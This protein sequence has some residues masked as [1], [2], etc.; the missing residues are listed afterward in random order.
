[1]IDG[2][3]GPQ[4]SSAS[5]RRPQSESHGWSFWPSCSHPE[6]TGCGQPCP[7]TWCVRVQPTRDFYPGRRTLPPRGE[8]KGQTSLWARPNS[9]LR[10][11]LCFLLIIDAGAAASRGL[12]REGGFRATPEEAACSW[13]PAFKPLLW[14][15]FSCW[16]EMPQQCWAAAAPKP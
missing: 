4:L 13:V 7:K 9:L 10:K 1:M 5:S 3:V 8:G 11:M 15:P 16:S 12:E 2:W 6:T 14:D